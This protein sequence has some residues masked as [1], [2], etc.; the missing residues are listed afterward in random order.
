MEEPNGLTKSLPSARLGNGKATIPSRKY[1][2]PGARSWRSRLF[3][4]I[5]R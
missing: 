1:G 4:T 3:N 5:A 2:A